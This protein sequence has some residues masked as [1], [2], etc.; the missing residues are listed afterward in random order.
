MARRIAESPSLALNLVIHGQIPPPIVIL[1]DTGI[2]RAG[3]SRRSAPHRPSVP[4]LRLPA[5]FK[6][7]LFELASRSG[8]VR[9]ARVVKGDDGALIAWEG[10]SK[11]TGAFQSIVQAAANHSGTCTRSFAVQRD[12]KSTRLNSSHLGIS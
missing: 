5:A 8:F 1:G 12:R 4:D 3:R 9:M 7:S 2:T 10:Q 11:D 6:L